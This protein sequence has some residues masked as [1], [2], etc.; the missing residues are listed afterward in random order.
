MD[1]T[2]AYNDVMAAETALKPYQGQELAGQVKQAVQQAWN[3]AMQNAAQ[4]T[5][6]TMADY[7][8]R[9]MNIPYSGIGAGTTAADLTPQ[10][11]MQRMGSELGGMAGRLAGQANLQTALG[12]NLAN[13]QQNA[14]QNLQYGQ[15]TLADQYNRAWQRYNTAQQ[16][17][18]S[19]R[20]RA[21]AGGGMDWSSLLGLLGKEVPLTLQ[22][23]Q[24]QYDILR[25]SGDAMG[26]R[27]LVNQ[28]NQSGLGGSPG[29][30]QQFGDLLA[31]FTN[32]NPVFKKGLQ[33]GGFKPKYSTL[34]TK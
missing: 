20:A 32:I 29:L 3:P 17:A 25:R 15:Q 7:L 18:E 24:K 14:M 13:M 9:F 11:Q 1:P 23:F 6:Q 33:I 19:A 8:N 30:G 22:D 10:Q 31:R 34:A 4:N 26:M 5:E 2:S 27:N 12:G 28:W 21:G 16:L